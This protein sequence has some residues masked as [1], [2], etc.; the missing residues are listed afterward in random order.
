VFGVFF[1]HKKHCGDGL[2]N[3]CRDADGEIR[4][5]RGDTLVKTL[6]KTYGPDFA[7]GVR[8]D[9]RLDTLLDKTNS[10]SLSDLLKGS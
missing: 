4:H 2:D 6:R 8:S 9:M 3:R 5:K 7:L 10:R 1:M